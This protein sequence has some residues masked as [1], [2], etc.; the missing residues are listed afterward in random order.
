MYIIHVSMLVR[1]YINIY[2][3]SYTHGRIC[4][5]ES[6]YVLRFLPRQQTT[7]CVANTRISLVGPLAPRGLKFAGSA[8]C[9]L[10]GL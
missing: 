10:L 8:L 9:S 6:M 7:G 2:K 5:C 4:V 3:Y 1:M